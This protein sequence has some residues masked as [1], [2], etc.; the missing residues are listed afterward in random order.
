MIFLRKERAINPTKKV[1]TK[2]TILLVLIS[3]WFKISLADR[4]MA[5]KETGIKRQKEKLKALREER[6]KR[7]P[8]KMVKPERETPGRMATA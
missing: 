2:A 7:R 8:E 4:I 3:D 6:P 5:P 1:R